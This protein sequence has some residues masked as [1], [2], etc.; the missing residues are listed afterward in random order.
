M[1]KY[2]LLKDELFYLYLLIGITLIV[3][4]IIIAV[5]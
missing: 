1:T 5:N 2:N 4:F 3:I